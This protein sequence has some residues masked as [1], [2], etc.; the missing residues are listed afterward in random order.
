MDTR[1]SGSKLA[2]NSST[3]L[4]VAQRPDQLPPE[5]LGDAELAASIVSLKRK[6]RGARRA[7]LMTR[8]AGG[9]LT[10]VIVVALFA[11][12]WAG[13]APFFARFLGRGAVT[14]TYDAVAWWIALIV[15]AIGG[16]L[17]GDQ[18]VSGKL[19]LARGWH[20]RVHDLERRLNEAEGVMAQRR[21]KRAS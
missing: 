2:P 20:R 5:S 19:K 13:P 12:L 14:T 7:L 4:F 15:L 18:V 21:G 8:A 10:V 17:F 16:V 1:T 6:L 9:A 11:L 3:P